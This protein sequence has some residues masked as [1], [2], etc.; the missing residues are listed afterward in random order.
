M[1]RLQQHA[2]WLAC[3]ARA[4]G[5]LHDQLRKPFARA[6]VDAK[7][8]FVHADDGDQG[9]VG[10]IVTL[11]QHLRADQDR[12]RIGSAELSSK[13]FECVAAARGFAIDAQ[14]GHVRELRDK[15]FFQAL[16]ALALRFQLGAPARRGRLPVR[17]VC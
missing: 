2:S 4:S 13:C 11:G 8:T 16:G 9:E 10:Q 15:R 1:M 7:Q 12:R 3:A 17:A 14:Y 5:H 6:E